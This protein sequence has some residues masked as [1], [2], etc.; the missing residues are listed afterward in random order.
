MEVEELEFVVGMDIEEAERLFHAH[1]PNLRLQIHRRLIMGNGH[2]FTTAN[3][4][5][6]TQIN[7]VMKFD[8]HTSVRTL[9]SKIHDVFGLKAT[10]LR[11]TGNTWIPVKGTQDWSLAEQNSESLDFK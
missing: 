9:V 10:V 6:T 11:L 4:I 2:V 5:D 3:P 1:Y 8:G 7:K